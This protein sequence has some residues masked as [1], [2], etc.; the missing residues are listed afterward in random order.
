MFPYS[1]I[2]RVWYNRPI[3]GRRTK[4]TESSPMEIKKRDRNYAYYLILHWHTSFLLPNR[5]PEPT[6]R[7][8]GARFDGAHRELPH[9]SRPTNTRHCVCCRYTSLDLAPLDFLLWNHVKSMVYDNR[10]RSVAQLQNSIH[11]GW[12]ATVWRLRCNLRRHIN[13]WATRHTPVAKLLLGYVRTFVWTWRH[14]STAG[15]T[16]VF[17]LY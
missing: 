16:T 4:W 14:F 11:T 15:H 2:I 9:D 13:V 10:Q 17:L 6:T 5:S 7:W 3:S 1:S 8:F 12:A